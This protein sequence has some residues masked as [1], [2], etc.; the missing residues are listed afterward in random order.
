MSLTFIIYLLL[1]TSLVAGAAAAAEWGSRA[2]GATRHAWTVAIALSVLGPLVATMWNASAR[3]AT[4]VQFTLPTGAVLNSIDFVNAQRPAA[5]SASALNQLAQSIAGLRSAAERVVEATPQWS[6][7]TAE[8]ALAAWLFLSFA[9][10]IWLVVGLC[11]LRRS[12]RGWTRST[13]D[14]VDVDVSPSAGPAVF[15]FT[16]H[17]IVLPEW[18]MQMESHARHLII[19][20][21]TEHIRARDPQRLAI[22]LAAL[23]VMP[24]NLALWWCAARLRRAIELDCDVRV[25]NRFPDARA[26]GYV[27]LDVASRGRSSGPLAISMVS[28]LRLP[29]ELELRLRAMSQTRK[30]GYRTVTIGAVLAVVSVSAAFT[31]PVPWPAQTQVR[32]SAT[33]TGGRQ[34][35]RAIDNAEWVNFLNQVQ[36]G[37]TATYRNTTVGGQIEDGSK[38]LRKGAT[39]SAEVVSAH[40]RG[41]TTYS[42]DQVDTSVRLLPGSASP[43]YPSD[44]RKQGV[45]GEVRAQF[46]VDTNGRVEPGTIRVTMSTDRRFATSV[47][48]ALPNVRFIPAERHGH[49]VRQLVRQPF[50]FAI[51]PSQAPLNRY[52][53][54]FP[55]QVDAPATVR[56][57]SPT[58][59][60]PPALRKLGIGG[61]VH[62]EFVVDTLGRV[63]DGSIK[64]TES[65]NQ[66][67][68]DA[69]LK[70]LPNMQFVPAEVHG[71]KVKQLVQMPFGF[72]PARAHK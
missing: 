12:R 41:D 17:R 71:Q 67:L 32:I 3:R 16:S 63:Q 35:D 53:T 37:S 58:P 52:Q 23:V 14:G 40:A 46:V 6:S 43:E 21:E 65:T 51:T 8:M 18:A 56:A 11:S 60:Y 30:A 70:A 48:A 54:Y 26:Y 62:A 20:H 31:A 50:T 61:E 4:S 66:E 10:C 49:K 33:A 38:E 15:G 69:V 7:A 22:A 24:W 64:I 5:H 39:P 36:S 44:L 45:E 68:T 19:A 28:L 9:L 57:G 55:Y 27:L 2:R 42:V 59:T 25:L 72:T 47:L 13:V 29:S 34:I 1:F